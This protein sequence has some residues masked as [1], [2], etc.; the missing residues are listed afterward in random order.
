MD[1]FAPPRG[2]KSGFKNQKFRMSFST[3]GVRGL[4]PHYIRADRHTRTS[5]STWNYWYL[6]RETGTIRNFFATQYQ[7]S[8]EKSSAHEGYKIIHE[9]N[10]KV[11]IKKNSRFYFDKRDGRIHNVLAPHLCLTT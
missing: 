2:F 9:N 4:T 5:T 8:V 11:T 6:D 1:A 7:L 10:R 3:G